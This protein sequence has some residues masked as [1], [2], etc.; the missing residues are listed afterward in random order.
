MMD[1]VTTQLL[2]AARDLG[3]KTVAVGKLRDLEIPRTWLGRLFNIPRRFVPVYG[4]SVHFAKPFD[5]GAFGHQV[6]QISSA[7][8]VNVEWMALPAC[9]AIKGKK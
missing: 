8:G 6:N 4:C 3:A 2:K 5:A 7:L 1:N 9:P